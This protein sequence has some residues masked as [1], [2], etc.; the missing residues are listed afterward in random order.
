MGECIEVGLGDQHCA[1]LEQPFDY[2]TGVRRLERLEDMAGSRGVRTGRKV[3]VLRGK[4][5][6]SKR[7]LLA[8]LHPGVDGL[9]LL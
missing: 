9:G 4:G 1:G 3:I 2:R 7:Q 6:P 5:Q 8:G